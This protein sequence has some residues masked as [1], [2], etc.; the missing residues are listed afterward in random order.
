MK[1][2]LQRLYFSQNDCYHWWIF[3][4]ITFSQTDRKLSTTCFTTHTKPPVNQ[5]YK[6]SV[7]IGNTNINSLPNKLEQL[8]ELVIKHIDGLV[9][10]ATKLHVTFPTSQYLR[11][12]FSESFRL[13]QNS[14]WKDVIK[15]VLQSDIREIFIELDFV[16]SRWFAPGWNYSSSHFNAQTIDHYWSSFLY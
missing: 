7:I 10:K 16:K 1:N 15:H 6:Y 8:K 9:I 5:Q 2:F 12:R 13:G 4:C 11:K 3:W 14:K